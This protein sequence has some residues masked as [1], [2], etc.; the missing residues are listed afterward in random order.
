MERRILNINLQ[1][2]ITNTEIRKR[3]K[4][5]DVIEKICALK[6]NWAGHIGRM[7]YNKWTRR[8]IEWRPWENKRSR[9]R[10]QTRWSDDIKRLAGHDWMRKTSNRE[11]WQ[12]LREAFTRRWVE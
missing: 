4:V 2:R 7:T 3:T 9:G 11:E 8:I 1:D 5:K 6:W 12:K 10:P